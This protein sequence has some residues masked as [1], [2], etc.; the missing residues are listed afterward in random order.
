MNMKTLT[1]MYL[2]NCPYCR[3]ARKALD[4]LLQE[5]PDF[6]ETPITW[7]EES[8]QPILA[9]S[10]DYWRVPS[11]FMGNEK[12]FEANPADTYESLKAAFSKALAKSLDP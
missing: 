1:V 4:E 10:Y 7:I 5:H 11:I 12:L 8:E 9:D 2:K 6:R 3:N